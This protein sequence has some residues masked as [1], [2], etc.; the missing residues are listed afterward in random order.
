[1]WDWIFKPPLPPQGCL[2]VNC[3]SHAV[4]GMH[5]QEIQFC[6]I[7]PGDIPG[8]I[9]FVWGNTS[10]HIK[11]LIYILL[12]VIKEKTLVMMSETLQ[13]YKR[14]LSKITNADKNV[15]TAPHVT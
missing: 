2:T 6:W 15:S 8:W 1:M 13:Q 10:D 4:A 12:R 5:D 7:A 3:F 14:P 9:K 11:G